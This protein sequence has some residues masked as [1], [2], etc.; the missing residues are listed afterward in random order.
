M[1]AGG[2]S[3]SGDTR[4]S[5]QG[6]TSTT[7]F[8]DLTPQQ[9]GLFNQGFGAVQ[10]GTSNSLLDGQLQSHMTR[11]LENTPYQPELC[12][13]IRSSMP[14]LGQPGQQNM[15]GQ[16][17][18]D[19]YSNEYADNS[20][21]RYANEVQKAMGMAR[22]GP[23]ATRG[24][25]AAQ[26]FLQAEAVND[27]GRNREDMVVRNRQADAS[28]G[29]G[30]AN[31]MGNVRSQTTNSALGGI[32]AQQGNFY[33]LMQDQSRA[34]GLTSDRTKQFNDMIPAFTTLASALNGVESNNLTGLG[35]QSAQSAGASFSLC[36]FIFLEAYNG[37][38][39]S[40]VR[41]YRDMKAPE[42]S[43]RRNGYIKMSRWLVPAMRMSHV[44]RCLTNYLLVK[45]LTC[46]GKW[47]YKENTIGWVFKP[48]EVF[49][50]GFWKLTG[51]N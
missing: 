33:N 10:P 18:R 35:N 19:V 45:P 38:L 25:T 49:W 15:E 37:Q 32:N 8:R 23:S 22:S 17:S 44:A 1:S 26:G 50:M 28:I 48:V 20:Y 21:N 46:Y 39:P 3:S 6:T 24:G 36:C 29:Q 14:T 7:S 42:S 51:K 13:I 31:T 9:E 11:G 27:M 12:N 47:Y 34:M 5:R 40:V 41:R 4:F 16:A 43:K 30:A 2:S